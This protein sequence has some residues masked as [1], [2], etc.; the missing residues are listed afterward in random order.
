MLIWGLCWGLS[1]VLIWG[2]C[3]GLSAVLIWGLC[4]G[5]SA[6]LIWGLCCGLQEGTSKFA[7]LDSRAKEHHKR[8]QKR[9]QLQRDTVRHRTLKEPTNYV[10]IKNIDSLTAYALVLHCIAITVLK[11][12]CC[13]RYI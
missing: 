5:L 11:L 7:S 4:W 9:L 6:V 1:A 13:A 10:S 12:L 2:L 8:S 3:W